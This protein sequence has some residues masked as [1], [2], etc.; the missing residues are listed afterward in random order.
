VT[1]LSYRHHGF[2]RL[3]GWLGRDV[4]PSLSGMADSRTAATPFRQ[5]SSSTPST[6]S[7]LVSDKSTPSNFAKRRCA[8]RKSACRKG[9]DQERAP[10]PCIAEVCLAVP[11]IANGSSKASVIMMPTT[12]SVLPFH[13]PSVETSVD[14][15]RLADQEQYRAWRACAPHSVQ[16]RPNVCA[17]GSR[18]ALAQ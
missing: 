9:P 6:P 3:T 7:R 4:A 17:S 18:A 15:S 11:G 14:P 10:Q 12:S 5:S 1:E 2:V 13:H 8:W 16:R